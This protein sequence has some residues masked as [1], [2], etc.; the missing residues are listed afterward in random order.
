MF[1]LSRAKAAWVAF[2]L[3]AAAFI[4]ATWPLLP[5]GSANSRLLVVFYVD[6]ATHFNVIASALASHAIATTMGYGYVFFNIVEGTL[7]LKPPVS[8]QQI[9]LALRTV[10]WAFALGTLVIVFMATLRASALAAVLTTALLASLPIFAR[11][12]AISHPDLVQLFFIWV[13]LYA[14]ARRLAPGGRR[15]WTLVAA[16][17]AGVAFGAKFAGMFLLPII[18]AADAIAEPHAAHSDRVTRLTRAAVVAGSVVALALGAALSPAFVAAHL[19][20]DGSIQ[21]AQTA[22][23]IQLGRVA[24]LASGVTGLVIGGLGAI[25]RR[26]DAWAVLVVSTLAVFLVAFTLTS[27]QAWFG[28]HFIRELLREASLPAA[29]QAGPQPWLSLLVATDMFTPGV[30]VFA[31]AGA[32]WLAWHARELRTRFAP[33]AVHAAWVLLFGASVA[34]S[35]RSHDRPSYYLLPIIPSMLFLAA[36]GW[37]LSWNALRRRSSAI[38]GLAAFALVAA[39]AAE[40]TYDTLR[41]ASLRREVLAREADSLP[42]QLGNRLACYLSPHARI[43]FDYLSYVPPA[44]ADAQATWGGTPALLH[45]RNPDAI[46]VNETIERFNPQGESHQY[47]AALREERTPYRV[48]AVAGPVRLY[49]RPDSPYLINERGCS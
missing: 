14:S 33:E 16:V 1:T 3:I 39:A 24:L 9:V 45:D 11:W 27:P 47:Y 21:L 40:L 42:V 13:A 25:W 2:A 46:I 34:M 41:M 18:W 6:E 23:V 38:A 5:I 10:E 28:L 17:A 32:L 49:L 48:A 7:L 43:V 19:T 31:L 37:E 8:E 35:L 20:R 30:V 26:L 15:V 12:S 36:R 29:D 44:F 22:H 4:R